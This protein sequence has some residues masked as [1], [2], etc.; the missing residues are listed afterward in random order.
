MA[1]KRPSFQFYSADWLKDPAVRSVSLAARG[2]WFDMLCL[3]DQSSR[4]GFLQNPSGK[5]VTAL[6]LARMSGSTTDEVSLLLPELENAGVYSTSETSV[7]FSR[8]MVRDEHKRELCS[9]AGRKGGGHPTFKQNRKVHPPPPLKVDIEDEVN[10][11]CSSDKESEESTLN[12]RAREVFEHYRTHHPKA[13]AVPEN[14]KK[15]WS[16]VVARLAEGYSVDDLK[17]AIDGC[18][19]CPHN[20]G[21]NERGTK[22]LALE[23]ICRTGSQV[24]RFMEV[25]LSGPVLSEKTR[26]NVRAGDSWLS[27]RT[28]D[29]NAL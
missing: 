4:R 13:H 29:D 20:Q 21:E 9:E 10:S 22:Y 19:R 14:A 25:P 7:I 11:N 2:L 17:S 16:L 1:A 8:R 24:T 28:G 18:H 23:L 3:M 12:E 6:E 27:K 5:P 15:E 26:R